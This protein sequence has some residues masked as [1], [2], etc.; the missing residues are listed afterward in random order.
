MPNPRC[1]G[2]PKL[3][4]QPKLN[5]ALEHKEDKREKQPRPDD[6]DDEAPPKKK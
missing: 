5:Q 2:L 4:N 3:W 1:E 6:C